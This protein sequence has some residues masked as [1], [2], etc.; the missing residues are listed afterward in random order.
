[1]F[2]E[3]FTLSVDTALFIDC[4]CC[5][6]L[7]NFL[8]SNVNE[9]SR[10][11]SSAGVAF[12]S[13]LRSRIFFRAGFSGLPVSLRTCSCVMPESSSGRSEIIFCMIDNTRKDVNWLI[14]SGIS[15]IRLRLKSRISRYGRLKT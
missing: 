15:V 10:S 6:P 4:C 11:A 13:P 9:G 2:S 12:F 7:R 8:I 14:L 1:M 3:I 5:R